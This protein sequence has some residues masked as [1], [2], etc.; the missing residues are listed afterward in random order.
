MSSALLSASQRA[1]TADVVLA[2]R[3]VFKALLRAVQYAKPARFVAR[4]H[5]RRAFRAGVR[6][7]YDASKIARTIEL[8][9]NAAKTRG[10]EHRIV[11]N[12]MHAWFE[13]NR[14]LNNPS[15]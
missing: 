13:Q 10:L 14:L 15:L 6:E 11:K 12:L 4:D 3:H 7:D 2:Y 5:V 1:T 8:L 9:D